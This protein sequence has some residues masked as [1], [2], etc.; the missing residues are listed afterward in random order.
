LQKNE[1]ADRKDY[2]KDLSVTKREKRKDD[3][4]YP[5]IELRMIPYLAKSQRLCSGGAC[6]VAEWKNEVG[7]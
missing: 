1:N 7:D 6:Y 4:E 5:E 3:D 2:I